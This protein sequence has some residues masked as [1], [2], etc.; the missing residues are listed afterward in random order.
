VQQLLTLGEI[1]S[2]V[3]G[4]M[5]GEAAE[6]VQSLKHRIHRGEGMGFS[7]SQRGEAPRGQAALELAQIMTAK[8]QVMQ[9]IAGTLPEVLMNGFDRSMQPFGLGDHLGTHGEECAEELLEFSILSWW[10][11]LDRNAARHRG[12]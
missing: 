12:S 5:P 4:R 7:R 8:R 2:P 3:N 9:K 6:A 1:K 10:A 11:F